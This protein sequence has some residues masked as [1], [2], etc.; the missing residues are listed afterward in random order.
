M[1]DIRVKHIGNGASFDV[2]ANETHIMS[3]GPRIRFLEGP[4]V[5]L[6]ITTATIVISNTIIIIT[7][8]III[9]ITMRNTWGQ[10]SGFWGGRQVELIAEL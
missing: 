4:P 7:T 1:K 3:L 6:I 5:D 2:T 8:I 10:G 9:A